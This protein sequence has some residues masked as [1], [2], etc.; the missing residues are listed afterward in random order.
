MKRK[1]AVNSMLALISGYIFIQS[2]F[3]T[4][5]YF[6]LTTLDHELTKL[7]KEYGHE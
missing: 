7:K 6:S 3:K 4:G 1:L 5:A 2:M